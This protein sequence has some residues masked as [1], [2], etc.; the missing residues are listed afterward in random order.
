MTWIRLSQ[1]GANPFTIFSKNLAAGGANRLVFR[2]T[3]AAANGVPKAELAD[4]DDSYATLTSSESAN[5][6]VPAEDWT[7]IGFAVNMYPDGVNSGVAIWKNNG[8]LLEVGNLTNKVYLDAATAH[9]NFVGVQ[10]NGSDAFESYFHG[11]MY[12]IE[13]YNS[14]IAGGNGNYDNTNGGSCNCSHSGMKCT[15][16]ATQCMAETAFDEYLDAAG[17]P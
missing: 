10:Q 5:N 4:N 17:S 9:T 2:A 14:Y 6:A 7:F 1:Y 16:I 13:I 12:K 8:D 15:D 11:F 3:L